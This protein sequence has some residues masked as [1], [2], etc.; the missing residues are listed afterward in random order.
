MQL[1][2][3]QA[4]LAAYKIYLESPENDARI[5]LWESQQ[6]FQ[7]QWNIE[8]FDMAAMYNRSLDSRHSRRMWNRENYEPKRMMGV[9]M[10]E[11]ADFVKQMFQD[12]FDEKKSLEGRASR[13]IFYC[14]QLLDDHRE[15][16]PKSR[17]DSHYHDDG[18]QIVSLYLAFR[19]PEVYSLYDLKSFQQLLEKLGASEIPKTHDLERYAKVC[20]TLYNMLQKET[21]ILTLHQQRLDPKYHFMEETM[22]LTYDFIQFLMVDFRGSLS[23]P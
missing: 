17:D 7:T 23:L 12:L 4:A 1:K 3:I 9:F 2:R 20:R 10:Q 11:Q 13:F 14:D 19:Y 15:R 8:A 5:Y 6:I 21:E 22:L 16:R 18:Y